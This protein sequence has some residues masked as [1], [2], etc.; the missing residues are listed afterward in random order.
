[1]YQSLKTKMMKQYNVIVKLS[2]FLLLGM[3]SFSIKLAAQQPWDSQKYQIKKDKNTLVLTTPYYTFEHDLTKGG[4]LQKIA[5][6]HGEEKNLLINPI[7]A[8]LGI[9]RSDEDPKA[10]WYNGGVKSYSILNDTEAKVSYVESE[11]WPIVTIVSS[12][13]NNALTSSGVQ[14]KS[15]YNYKWGYVKIHQEVLF[16]KEPLEISYLEII[17]TK[18]APSL[19]HY[20]YIPGLSESTSMDNLFG[21]GGAHVRQWGRIRPGTHIDLPLK[22]RNL[23]RYLVFA[24]QGKEGLEWF[25]A[26]DLS[27]W[28]FQMTEGVTGTGLCS[29]AAVNDPLGISLR[30]QPLNLGTRYDLPKGGF[31]KLSGTYTFDYYLGIPIKDGKAFTPWLESGYR[32]NEGKWVSKEKI[33]EKVEKGVNNMTLHNDGSSKSG[34]F[35]ADGSY[36]PYP[37]KEMKKMDKTINAIHEAGI[38]TTPYFSN[39]ELHPSTPE[40]KTHAKEWGR[41]VD[42]QG[43]LRPNNYF[44]VHMCLKSGWF[45]YFKHSVDRVLKNHDFDG[46]YYDWNVPLFCSNPLHMGAKKEFVPDT[47]GYAAIA[48]NPN[49]HWDIDEL[50]QLMEWSRERVG[51][52]GLLNIH[53]TLMPMFTTENFANGVAGLE[54]TYGLLSKSVPHPS[55]MPL[56]WSFAGARKRGIITYGTLEGKSS[57]ELKRSFAITALM[58]GV[59]PWRMTAETSEVFKILKPLGVLE[60]YNF[61]DYRNT[62]VTL[63]STKCLS[64]IYSKK[65]ISYVLIANPTPNAKKVA[66]AINS[67]ELKFPLHTNAKAEYINGGK[68]KNTVSKEFVGLSGEMKIE[69]NQI[70]MIKIF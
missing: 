31:A 63:N 26:D 5:L 59:C 18:L 28:N 36:P 65:D 14:L 66:Y 69:S 37:K 70:V 46:V 13:K 38:T 60:L 32:V 67:K 21:W 3:L 44:S 6:T 35:W 9:A 1:M 7:G 42:D 20:G 49:T 52:N 55:E 50:I 51:P 22:L 48:N 47:K 68:G 43:N 15:V 24:N 29:A 16:P 40:F 25:S 62:A 41:M 34:L 23:P 33:K 64:A 53:N 39:H 61:Q 45:D 54:F 27:Q 56:E 2:L 10:P 58:T 12:F 57:P 11:G 8:S 19:D 30:I 17:S 4:A